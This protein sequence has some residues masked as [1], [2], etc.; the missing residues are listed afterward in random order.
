[1]DNKKAPVVKQEPFCCP[2]R[3]LRKRKGCSREQPF[4]LPLLVH[5]SSG[6]ELTLDFLFFESFNVVTFLQ[7][8]EVFHR[9]TAFVTLAHF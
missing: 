1:M 3:S 4:L 5:V 8:I 7:V 2:L 9:N 6:L